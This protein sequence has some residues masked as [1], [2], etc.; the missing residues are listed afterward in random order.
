MA[1]VLKPGYGGIMQQFEGSWKIQAI[2]GSDNKVEIQ[3]KLRVESM[4]NKE[5]QFDGF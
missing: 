4:D 1:F 2:P 5:C 3:I